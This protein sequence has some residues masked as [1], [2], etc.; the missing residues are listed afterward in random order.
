[1]ISVRVKKI[2]LGI[3]SGEVF[4]VSTVVLIVSI[5]AFNAAQ[6]PTIPWFP[7]PLLLF[8]GWLVYTINRKW[9]IGL[10]VPEDMPKGL[11]AGFAVTSMIAAHAV[12][13]L[14][15]TV[16]GIT[17]SFEVAPPGVSTVFAVIYWIAIVLAMST[18]SEVGYRGIMQSRLMKVMGVWPAIAIVAF[19]NLI[20][21][22]FEGLF[23]RTFGVIA[24]L[25]AWCYLRHL[26]RSLTPTIITH[27]AAIFAWDI[28]LFVWGPWQLDEMGTTGISITVVAGLMGLCGAIYF[29]GKIKDI[30]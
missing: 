22:R 9:D 20:S 4:F 10:A 3:L 24:I 27:M 30:R 23:E 2:A 19:M 14:E 17:K 12:L 26:S 11:L 25:L 6:M 28:I 15:G 13:V 21:H 5:A 16:H 18:A 29:A 7:L 1:M 8:I